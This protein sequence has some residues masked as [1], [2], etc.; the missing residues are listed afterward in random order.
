[1]KYR[2]QKIHPSEGFS[3]EIHDDNSVSVGANSNVVEILK[4]SS[5]Q[6]AYEHY[7]KG[8]NPS[9]VAI[10]NELKDWL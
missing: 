10:A 8:S 9:D 4:F 3:L 1:M 5:I 7:T 6:A 2:T